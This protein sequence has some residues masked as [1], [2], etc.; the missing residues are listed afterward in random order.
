M[1]TWFEDTYLNK[2]IE[3][4]NDDNIFD[5]NKKD[6]SSFHY[7]KEVESFLIP[8]KMKNQ[9]TKLMFIS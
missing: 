6:D 9:L 5:T 3:D 4:I 7:K 1:K 8:R 2:K